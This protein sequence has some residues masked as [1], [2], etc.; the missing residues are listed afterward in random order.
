MS[1]LPVVS[2]YRRATPA[3]RVPFLMNPVSST[4]SSPP[5]PSRSTTKER[6]SS[7][8]VSAFQSAGAQR[9]LHAVRGHV[10]VA[11]GLGPA[12]VVLLVAVAVAVD[13]VRRGSPSFKRTAPGRYG[14]AANRHERIMTA[15]QR[16]GQRFESPQPETV[17]Q[18][19]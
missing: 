19:P 1:I 4:I 8:T 16:G 2:V 3:D 15:W 17:G 9:P 5:R 12:V 6:S 14:T 11:L 13:A 7:R 10:A 18:R